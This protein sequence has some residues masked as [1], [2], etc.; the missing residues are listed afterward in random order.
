MAFNPDFKVVL[1]LF[2]KDVFDVDHFFSTGGSA[3]KESTC[4][5]GYLGLI[6]G[7]GISPGEGNSFPL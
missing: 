7:L 4:N 2:F 1:F 5:A 3:G 6:P